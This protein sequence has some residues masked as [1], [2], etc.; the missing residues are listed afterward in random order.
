MTMACVVPL[1]EACASRSVRVRKPDRLHERG[2]QARARACSGAAKI[3]VF[4]REL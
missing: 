3:G 2:A 4:G 1:A